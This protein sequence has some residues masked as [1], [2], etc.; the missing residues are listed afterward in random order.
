MA[1]V[2]NESHNPSARS[3]LVPDIA[4]DDDSNLS[5]AELQREYSS[6]K[7]RNSSKML[8]YSKSLDIDSYLNSEILKQLR[9]ELNEE[10]IDNEFDLKVFIFLLLSFIVIKKKCV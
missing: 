3:S 8:R 2:G 9:R 1:T 6:S 7:N 5:S 4:G 10:V